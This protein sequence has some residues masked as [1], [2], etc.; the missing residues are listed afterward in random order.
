MKVCRHLAPEPPAAALPILLFVSF[1]KPVSLTFTHYQTHTTHTHKTLFLSPL[2]LSPLSLSTCLCPS[3]KPTVCCYLL[4]LRFFSPS[5]PSSSV[6]SKPFPFDLFLSVTDSFFLGSQN[7]PV[8][9]LPF[10][11]DHLLFLF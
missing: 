7:S 5:P 8:S 3:V 11:S 4:V 10:S 6:S 1:R 9:D 2:S